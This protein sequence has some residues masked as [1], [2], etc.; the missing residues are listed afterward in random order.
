MVPTVRRVAANIVNRPVVGRL[1]GAV[2]E[3]V[4]FCNSR[5]SF[6]RFGGLVSWRINPAQELAELRRQAA[7]RH[8]EVVILGDK[9]IPFVLRHFPSGEPDARIEASIRGKHVWL[10]YLIC[11]GDQGLQDRGLLEGLLGAVARTRVKSINLA[12][13]F[14]NDELEDQPVRVSREFLITLD[15]VYRVRRLMIGAADDRELQMLPLRSL[16]KTFDELFEAQKM[17]NSFQPRTEEMTLVFTGNN[18]EFEQ[19]LQSCLASERTT[20]VFLQPGERAANSR[21]LGALRGKR[22]YVVHTNRTGPDHYYRDKFF[23]EDVL[24]TLKWSFPQELTLINLFYPCSRQERKSLPRTPISAKDWAYT[25][26]QVYRISAAVFTDLHAPAIQGFYQKPVEHLTMK[27]AFVQPIAELI[28]SGSISR[29]HFVSPDKSRTAEVMRVARLID[30]TMKRE[31]KLRDAVVIVRK[32]KDPQ[33]RRTT[34]YLIEDLSGEDAIIYDDM[35][36]TAGTFCGA[37]A[38]CR[39]KGA[40]S[41]TVVAIF[42]VFSRVPGEDFNGLERLLRDPAIDRVIVTDILPLPPLNVT[43]VERGKLQII[44]AAPIA[45]SAVERIHEHKS[46]IGYEFDEGAGG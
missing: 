45:A 14:E 24:A 46:L 22:V 38:A 29:P 33:T 4:S 16:R 7:L 42:G 35:V 3:A 36:D 34:S 12:L 37:A 27:R 40:R 18:H 8:E 9:D 41:V 44:S 11:A 13:R 20:A 17:L 6:E 1:G 23:L 26:E 21:L 25:M 31:V 39:K 30:E 5:I 15:S 43:D 32:E 19:R 10:E 28:G 2:S